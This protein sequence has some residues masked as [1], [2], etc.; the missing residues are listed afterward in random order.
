[1]KEIDTKV[2]EM[3]P[4]FKLGLGWSFSSLPKPEHIRYGSAV[5][6]LAD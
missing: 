5:V 3:C 4:L 1:M 2:E 6:C